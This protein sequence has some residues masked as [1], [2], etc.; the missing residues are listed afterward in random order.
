MPCTAP[1]GV[2]ERLLWLGRV[3]PPSSI[4]EPQIASY[5]LERREGKHMSKIKELPQKM[6]VLPSPEELRQSDD[7]KTLFD[8]WEAQSQRVLEENKNL[9]ARDLRIMKRCD[10]LR[11]FMNRNDHFSWCPKQH[12]DEHWQELGWPPLSSFEM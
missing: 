12:W 6:P 7:P 10:Y 3:N 11:G 1:Q 5:G 2:I 9:F 8:H 4:S